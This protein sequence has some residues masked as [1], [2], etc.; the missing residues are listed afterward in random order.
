MNSI[1]RVGLTVAG[2]VTAMVVAGVLAF[3]GYASAIAS[4]NQATPDAV[5]QTA[6]NSPSDGSP[7]P[8]II[9]VLP[10]P[11]PT[12]TPTVDPAVD[13]GLPQSDA[14]IDPNPTSASTQAPAPARTP[15]PTRSGGD[16]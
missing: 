13:V 16:D 3:D 5:T 4:Q 12:A 10:A 11:T 6:P 7:A 2:L 1:H 9:Y 14:T 8:T 15:R